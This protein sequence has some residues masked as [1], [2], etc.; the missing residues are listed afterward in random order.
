MASTYVFFMI[1]SA[2]KSKKAQMEDNISSE[3]EYEYQYQTES[4]DFGQY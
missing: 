4:Y 3:Y 2:Y 1:Y